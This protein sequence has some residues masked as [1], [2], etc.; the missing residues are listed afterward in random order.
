MS[1][2]QRMCYLEES[3]LGR[4]HTSSHIRHADDNYEMISEYLSKGV[5]I[6]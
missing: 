5:P 4:H 6:L 1:L 3:E 2:W